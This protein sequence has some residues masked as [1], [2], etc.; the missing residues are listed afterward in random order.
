MT[1]TPSASPG[2]TTKA[3]RRAR[4][5]SKLKRRIS[6]VLALGVALLGAGALYA[7]FVP[8]P[9]TAQASDT[10]ALLQKGEQ[11]YNNTC[12]TC[13]GQ[14]LEGVKDRGPSLVGVGSAAS[15]FQLSTGR[16]P[17]AAQTAE[18]NRKPAKFTPEEIDAIDAYIQAHGGG[19]EKPTETGEA[20]RGDDPARGGELFRLN[21]ANCHSFTGRGGALSSGKF[22]PELEGVTEDQIYTAMLTGPENMPVFGDRQLTPAEKKD[23]IAYIKSVSDGNNN[24]GGNALGGLGPISEGLIGWIVGIAALVGVTLWIGAKA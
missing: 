16:M 9:Q 21:C 19:K 15:Y 14:N 22:A 4:S 24:P 5:R 2:G 17:L 13:H 18:A 6:G 1:T 20:L 8:E 11:L 3:G 10:S 12:V 23:I 7:G